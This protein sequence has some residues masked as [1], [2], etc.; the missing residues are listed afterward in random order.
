M[1]LAF[2][3]CNGVRRCTLGKVAGFVI[4]CE[5]VSLSLILIAI[6][7]ELTKYLN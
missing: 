1:T 6:S 5:K 3:S 2:R 7:N 4:P